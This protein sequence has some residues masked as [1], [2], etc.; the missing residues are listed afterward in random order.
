MIFIQFLNLWLTAIMRKQVQSN[1]MRY[2][3]KYVIWRNFPEKV[4][5][6]ALLKVV[7]GNIKLLK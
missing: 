4:E 5:P 3:Q 2:I 7:Q 6:K 1:Y